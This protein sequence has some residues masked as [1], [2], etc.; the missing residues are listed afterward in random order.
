M[1]TTAVLHNCCPGGP[2]GCLA[3]NFAL[4]MAL[5]A[6]TMV[7][8]QCC[9]QING[10]VDAVYWQCLGMCALP[11]MPINITVSASLVAKGATVHI[12]GWTD[13]LYL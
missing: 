12:G 1:A 6:N 4:S 10:S 13:V 5:L 9:A 2:A 7:C 8:Q 3:I 11:A